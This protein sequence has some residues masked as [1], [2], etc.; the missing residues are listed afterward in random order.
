MA[1]GRLCGVQRKSGDR[2]F[3]GRYFLEV[4][5]AWDGEPGDRNSMGLPGERPAPLNESR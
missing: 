4:R 3:R 2:R 5:K 1:R